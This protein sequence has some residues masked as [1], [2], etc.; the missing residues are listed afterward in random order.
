M[1]TSW[2][3][4]PDSFITKLVQFGQDTILSKQVLTPTPEDFPIRYDG[5]QTSLIKTAEI[6]ATQMDV[7]VDEVTLQTYDENIKAFE[8]Q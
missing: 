1:F 8:F 2:G 6:V 5:T 4:K 7:N 3:R